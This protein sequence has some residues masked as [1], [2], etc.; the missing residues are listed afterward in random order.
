MKKKIIQIAFIQIIYIFIYFFFESFLSSTSVIFPY[1]IH[2]FDIVKDY[3]DVWIILKKYFLLSNMLI[4][5][6][7]NIQIFVDISREM[8]TDEESEFHELFRKIKKFILKNKLL[9]L[10]KTGGEDNENIIKNLNV[11]LGFNEKKEPIYISEKSLFQNILITGSIGTG[12]TS[13]AI[14][15]I[16]RQLLSYNAQSEDKKIGGLILDVKGNF[17]K[18]IRDILLSLR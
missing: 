1:A 7:L 4:Y 11:F 15:P 6:I 2:P 3:P 17:H 14:Y 8:K 18:E 5:F 16:T 10:N 13:S 9:N 12:K